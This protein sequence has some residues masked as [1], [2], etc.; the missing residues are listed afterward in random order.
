MENNKLETLKN[1]EKN[2]E[3]Y[4]IPTKLKCPV[5]KTGIVLL[6]S[7][8]NNG[9]LNR[10]FKCSHNMAPPFNRCN[11]KGGYYGSE[12][13]DL[14]DIKHCPN[15]DG[16]LIKRRRHSDGHPFLGC[17]NFKETG[18]RGKSKLEYIG[19]NCP[20]C[21]KPLVKRHNGEDNSLFIGCSGF[22]K[23]RHTEPFEEKEMG[24]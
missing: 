13:K 19:K 20:K 11:W 7:F 4:A 21:S 16:I 15:C 3:R 6:E 22:P 10:V 17:T 12:L 5:C 23:C 18:C 24:S 8:W 2:G 14:D 9:K 1:I